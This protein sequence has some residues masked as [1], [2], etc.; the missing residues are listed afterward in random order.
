MLPTVAQKQSRACGY[1]LWKC[2]Q[3]SPRSHLFPI[4]HYLCISRSAR[5]HER[6]RQRYFLSSAASAR[7]S[8]ATRT[9][10]DTHS[11]PGNN[12]P[13]GELRHRC[14]DRIICH[15]MSYT[16]ARARA[17]RTQLR[18]LRRLASVKEFTRSIQNA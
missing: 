7:G 12:F 4:N 13:R 18:G 5:A 9:H 6:G 14:G 8:T 3:Y 10:T 11:L 2:S 1:W 16:H 17:H 15:M